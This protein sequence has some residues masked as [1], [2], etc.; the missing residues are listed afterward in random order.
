M[1]AGYLQ[2]ATDEPD[3]RQAVVGIDRGHLAENDRAG[4]L[5]RKLRHI[6]LHEDR[7]QIAVCND[8]SRVDDD[9]MIAE[10]ADLLD[11]MADVEDRCRQ[12]GV[13]AIEERQ[14]LVPAR[15]IERRERLVHQHEARRT[16]QRAPDRDALRLAA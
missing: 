16:Q 7:L 6:H 8:S 3:S 15:D 9:E 13:Q 10:P 14:D 5:A 11:V 4:L 12:F 2:L 1:I